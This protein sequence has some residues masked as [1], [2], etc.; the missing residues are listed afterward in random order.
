MC[1]EAAVMTTLYNYPPPK[2]V[3]R[4]NKSQQIGL[5]FAAELPAE[6]TERAS[7]ICIPTLAKQLTPSLGNCMNGVNSCWLALCFENW[8]KEDNWPD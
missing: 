8:L 6:A 1:P 3:I 7:P 5:S 4:I 2:K